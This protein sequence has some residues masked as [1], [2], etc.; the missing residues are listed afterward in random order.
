MRLPAH[1]VCFGGG[2]CSCVVRMNA[3]SSVTQGAALTSSTGSKALA[4][5][6]IYLNME[7]FTEC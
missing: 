5:L 1:I 2:Y 3:V 4:D 7:L 6:S